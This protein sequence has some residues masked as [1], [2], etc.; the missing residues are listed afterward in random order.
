MRAVDFVCVGTLMLDDILYPG[1]D[2]AW[3]TL[4]GS[5]VHA[6]AGMRVWV[7]RVGLVARTGQHFPS[8]AQAQLDAYGFETSGLI[9]CLPE[10]ARAFQRFDAGERRHEEFRFPP[11]G[12]G[13]S[14]ATNEF[15]AAYLTASGFHLMAGAV[16]EHIQLAELLRGNSSAT[17]LVEPYYDPI[18]DVRASDLTLMLERV[19]VFAPDL[20]E[21]SALTGTDHIPTMLDELSA[22]GTIVVLRMGKRGALI[23]DAS[24]H[25]TFLIPSAARRIVDVT[26]AGNAFSGAWLAGY[27]QYGDVVRAGR[28]ATVAASFAVEQ[29]GPVPPP[30]GVI[31]ERDRRYESVTPTEY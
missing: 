20:A 1:K 14:I 8:S 9:A 12:Q 10:P 4:G 13:L 2:W 26:G 29:L 19:H 23:R 6:A 27:V 17:I 11:G 25:R 21:A 16:T 30:R 3:A 5:A 7:D 31:A 18:G 28:M 24:T 22:T 15:P